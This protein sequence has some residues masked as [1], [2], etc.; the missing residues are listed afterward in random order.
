VNDFA[1][2]RLYRATGESD[3]SYYL[4][5]EGTARKYEDTDVSATEQ[6]F[7]Y[8]TAYDD[9][10]QN[11]EDPGVSLESGRFWCWTGWITVGV[12]PSNT[13][14]KLGTSEYLSG[15]NVRATEGDIVGVLLNHVSHDKRELFEKFIYEIF[16]PKAKILS[17]REQQTFRQLRVLKPVRMNEDSTY[18]YVLL[19]DPLVQHANYNPMS[20]YYLKKMY[21][22]EKAKEYMKMFKES[23][24]FPQMDYF[25]IQSKY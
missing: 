11:W 21:G 5:W 4:I 8:L 7:Y 25:V 1:G 13:D 17:G 20:M 23:L 14:I 10:N 18:T 2:Y 19:M 3:S 12:T 9:G 15:A 22:N 24:K 16:I 6:Y